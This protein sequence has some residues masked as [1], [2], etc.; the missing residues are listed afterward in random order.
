M[1]R[2]NKSLENALDAL[3]LTGDELDTISKDP[4]PQAFADEDLSNLSKIDETS[5][6][7]EGLESP[8]WKLGL[9]PSP[10]VDDD[11][12]ETSPLTPTTRIGR[13]RSFSARLANKFDV[14]LF[15]FFWTSSRRVCFPN[16]FKR[17][18][19]SAKMKK[20]KEPR[21]MI[22]LPG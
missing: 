14:M 16:F 8:K 10:K 21:L 6:S 15:F 19:M 12:K 9:P 22:E 11:A 18:K 5:K 2:K 1:D 13:A 3:T 4:T 7:N 20:F 17:E